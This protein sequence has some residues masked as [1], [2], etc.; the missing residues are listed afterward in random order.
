MKAESKQEKMIKLCILLNKI[1]QNIIRR[2]T[3]EGIQK[4]VHINET[5]K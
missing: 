4:L 5:C 2:K 1:M 3:E